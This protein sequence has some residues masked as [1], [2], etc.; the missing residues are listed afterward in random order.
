M[1]GDIIQY[2]GETF[3]DCANEMWEDN[4]CVRCGGFVNCEGGEEDGN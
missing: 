4:C 1:V 3:C 2:E